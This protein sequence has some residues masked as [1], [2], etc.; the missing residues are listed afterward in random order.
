VSRFIDIRPE[1]EGL[2]AELVLRAGDVV[3]FAATGGGVRSG[4][5]VELLGILSESV[6]GTDG[7]VLTPLDAPGVV[8]LRAQAPGRAVVD[9]VSGDPFL[10]P[11]S[12]SVVIRVEP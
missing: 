12:R 2:P 7:S 8:L 4:T 5:G 10:S 6:V 11:V 9:V 1:E 3:R